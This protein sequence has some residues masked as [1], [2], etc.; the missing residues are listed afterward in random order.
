MNDTVIYE[1]L[2]MNP[3]WWKIQQQFW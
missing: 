1:R 2:S 3:I